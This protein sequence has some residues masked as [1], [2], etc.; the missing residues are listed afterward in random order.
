[1]FTKVLARGLHEPLEVALCSQDPGTL[2][3]V[4]PL[5]S[6]R[7]RVRPRVTGFTPPVS[8]GSRAAARVRGLTEL[9]G[10]WRCGPLVRGAHVCGVDVVGALPPQGHTA[11]VSPGHGHPWARLSPRTGFRPCC[12][13]CCRILLINSVAHTKIFFLPI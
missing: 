10:Q 3:P 8:A 12:L 7:Q 6:W 9:S 4:G 5:C 13:L 2:A 11:A 1:M